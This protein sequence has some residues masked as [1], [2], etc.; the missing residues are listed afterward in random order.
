MSESDSSVWRALGGVLADETVNAI[1]VLGIVYLGVNGVT[2]YEPVAAITS[3]AL[4][5]KYLKAKTA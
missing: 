5:A 4:G 3:I 2:A 1:A